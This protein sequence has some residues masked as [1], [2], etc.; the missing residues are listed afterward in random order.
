MVRDLCRLERSTRYDRG[1]RADVRQSAR[2]RTI[3]GAQIVPR[4]PRR[5]GPITISDDDQPERHRRTQRRIERK[6]AKVEAQT[7]GGY[8]GD[9]IIETLESHLEKACVRYLEAKADSPDDTDLERG[10]IRGL[11]E[12]VALWRNPYTA[13]ESVKGVEKEFMRRAREF[14]KVW[15]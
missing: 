3:G 5:R 1:I 7:H 9:S 4:G 13:R 15:G 6:A 8:A 12:A 14:Q 10:I 2:V 11:A